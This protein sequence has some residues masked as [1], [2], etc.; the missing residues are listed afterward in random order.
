MSWRA[1]RSGVLAACVGL[2]AQIHGQGAP[3]RAHPV[4]NA[5]SPQHEVATPPAETVEDE[6]A[7]VRF[8]LPAGWE[9][10]RRDGELSTFRLDARTALRRTELRAVA[11]LGFNPYPRSTFSGALFYLSV[12]P[13]T[14]AQACAGQATRPPMHGLGTASVGDVSFTHG[15]D[16][17]GKI[18]TEARDEVY[19]AMRGGS[20][21]RFDL[22]VNSFCGGEVSGAED[23]TAAQLTGIQARLRAILDSVQFTSAH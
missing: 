11:Q 13:H 9:L 2:A 22:A 7:H 19:T 14:A 1:I 18:C 20:C 15:H 3:L 4:P 16:E 6:R 12:T 5:Q 21:V 17:H 10:A 23:L 8:H